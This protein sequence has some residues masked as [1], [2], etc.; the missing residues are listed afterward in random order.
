[1]TR[2]PLKG[3][4]AS[5]IDPPSGARSTRCEVAHEML[6]DHPG[7]AGG[8]DAIRADAIRAATATRGLRRRAARGGERGGS[9]LMAVAEPF[10]S[11]RHGPRTVGPGA[12]RRRCGAPRSSTASAWARRSA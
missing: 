7:P 2:I 4:P 1:V 3:E 12:G 6:V 9:G 10:L 8:G 11:P 5:A